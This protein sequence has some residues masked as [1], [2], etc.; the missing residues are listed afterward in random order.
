M[1][2]ASQVANVFGNDNIIVQVLGSGVN[3]TVQAGRAYLRLTQYER[4]TKLATR[5]N[6]EVALLSAYRADVVQLIGRDREMADLRRWLNEP[7]DIS[8]RVLVGAGGR[9]KTRLALELARAI[10]KEGWLAGFVTVEE[11]DRFRG[12]NGIEQWRWDKPVLVMFDYA[13][14]RAS[15]IGSWLRELVDASLEDRPKLRLLLLERQANR[16]AG[17][18]ATAFGLGDDDDSRAAITLLDPPEPV[19]LPAIAEVEFRRE[20][21]A[22]LL[23]SSNSVWQAPIH[24][25]DREFDRKLAEHKWA[26]DP[27]FLMMAGLVAAR[28]G[29][30]EALSLSRAD[31]ALSIARRELDRIG[32]IGAAH[33]V[34]VKQSKPG[35]FVRHMAVMA[36]LTEGLTLVEARTLAM[37]EC[38]AN[39]SIASLDATIEALA[40]A[41]PAPEAKGIAP[42]V[43]D[44][45]GEGAVLAWF[46]PDGAAPGTGVDQ[47]A[48]IAAAAKVSLEGV[49]RTLVRTAQD[50]AGQGFVEPVRWLEGL[51]GA[52]ETDRSALMQIAATLPH[53]TIA[54]R[55]LAVIIEDRIARS[56][57][58]A[59]V[60]ESK[61]SS[62]V[63]VQSQHAK[64]LRN[65]AHRLMDLGQ[66]EEAVSAAQEATD[67][68]R[69]LAAERPA[70][71]LPDLARSLDG[72][73]AH[74]SDLGR[75]EQA[76]AVAQEATDINRRL[77][78]ERP[79]SFLPDLASSLGSLTDR[80]SHLGQSE[81]ALKAA[82][83]QI[84]IYRRLSAERPDSFLPDLASSLSSLNVRLTGLGP[85]EEMLAAA[86]E[87][88]DIDRQLAVDRPDVFLPI[89]ASSLENLFNSLSAVHLLEEAVTAAREAVDI[90]RRLA[91]ERPDSFLPDLAR[92]VHNLSLSLNDVG[93]K[94]EALAAGR[95]VVAVWRRLAAEQPA[96][97]LPDLAMSLNNL[98]NR[99]RHRGRIEEALEATSE[100]TDIRRR[101]AAERPDAYLPALVNSLMN[102]SYRLMDVGRVED[103][104]NATR[105]ATDIRRQLAAKWPDFFLPDLAKSLRDLSRFLSDL[106]RSEEAIATAREAVEVCRRLVA[107]RPDDFL[108]AFAISLHHLVACLRNFSSRE[109]AYL[110]SHEAVAVLAPYF[111]QR[112]RSHAKWMRSIAEQYL[113]ICDRLHIE[114]NEELLGPIRKQLQ[115]L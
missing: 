100:A 111:L 97:F 58:A 85:S 81:E 107:E 32:K 20:L 108:N 21:F 90:R 101:L 94:E 88:A 8:V 82:R 49:S 43:P 37:K 95:E 48:G 11:L 26:G 15:Q 39:G 105:E 23:K 71:F 18:L 36:T 110:A 77:A 78:A 12:Q 61:A 89:L 4:R 6:S 86:R 65:L 28:A 40:D 41:L 51:A 74:L 35:A 9:G 70:A 73:G 64:T 10:S 102:L 50:F 66:F 63:R 3:V 115:N 22:A 47:P 69:R 7:A 2:S 33:G 34:D 109:E 42:I 29:V 104:L 30:H 98:G 106:S 99:L 52:P 83:E 1:N 75:R 92:S 80:L 91:A 84:D 53:Q 54:L 55:E 67:I 114:P 5:D 38:K 27:L 68:N 112:P 24:G 87:A 62:R 25:A 17:W 79:D 45:I 46:R 96:A 14:S 16:T 59:V 57:S 103:A 56:L 72:L 13:A 113:E 44:I 19:D 76:L 93:Q 31:L 60:E